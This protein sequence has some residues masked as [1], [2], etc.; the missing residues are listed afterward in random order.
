MSDTQN[1]IQFEIRPEDLQKCMRA[2]DVFNRVLRKEIIGTAFLKATT[3]TVNE[4][5]LRTPDRTGNLR[6]S[7]TN[8]E[9]AGTYLDDIGARVFARR[10]KKYRHGY[11]AHLIEY[12]SRVV[13]RRAGG[14]KQQVGHQPARPFLRPAVETTVGQVMDVAAGLISTQVDHLNLGG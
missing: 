14:G 2:L 6:E 7:L 3:I 13:V 8:E 9:L 11:L 5:K 10:S 12:G 1:A 4:A